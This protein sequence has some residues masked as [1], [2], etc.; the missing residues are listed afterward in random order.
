MKRVAGVLLVVAV[1]LTGAVAAERALQRVERPDPLGRK[2]LYLPSAEMLRLTSLGNAGLVADVLYLWS[3]QYY[4]QYGINDRFL[5]LE[6][7]YDLITDLDTLYH[8]AYRVGALIIQLPNTDE[9]VHKKAVVHL[10]DKALRNMPQNHEIAEAAAWDMYIRYRDMANAL[11]YLKVAA[12]IPGSPHR[13][14]RFLAAWSEDEEEWS[15]SNAISYWIEVRETAK[16]DYD[17]AVCEKQIYRLVASRDEELLNPLL[18]DW[19]AR[20]GR[21]P[22]S[23]EPL[24]EAGW[25]DRAPVDYFG[26]SYRILPESCSSMAAESVR[27]D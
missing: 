9:E 1:L 20:Q 18:G 10:F 24:V 13:L 5:Y 16:T 23:W 14:K 2:L 8:D 11:R 25:L 15:F 3:I 7:V 21:C 27:F 22:E 4:A 26:Q 19:M 12:A 17:R 6:T